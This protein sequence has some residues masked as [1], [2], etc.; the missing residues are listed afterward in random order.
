[1]SGWKDSSEFVP[2][3]VAAADGGDP[4]AQARCVQMG[5]G[6]RPRDLQG[7]VRLF[8]AIVAAAAS[9]GAGGHPASTVDHPAAAAAA[10]LTLRPP[11][12]V[13]A[14]APQVSGHRLVPGSSGHVSEVSDPASQPRPGTSSSATQAAERA[15]ASS[16]EG[17]LHGTGATPPPAVRPPQAVSSGSKRRYSSASG[18]TASGADGSVGSAAAVVVAIAGGGKVASRSPL[19]SFSAPLAMTQLALCSRDGYGEP[20]SPAKAAKWAQ[21]RALPPSHPRSST[22]RNHFPNRTRRPAPSSATSFR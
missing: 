17:L 12:S 8:E 1:M 13:A 18:S 4:F 3:F 2:L 10:A 15:P 6:G 19:A 21:V 22:A 14:L 5:W 11:A 7:A 16:E 20:T 9:A